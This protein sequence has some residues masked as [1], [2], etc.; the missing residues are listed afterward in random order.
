M[1]QLSLLEYPH[2]PPHR[3]E[4]SQIDGA[5][6]IAPDM[7]RLQLAILQAIDHLDGATIEELVRHTGLKIPT[8]CGRIGELKHLGK[9]REATFKRLSVAGVNVK[10]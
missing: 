3:G 4:P 2:A 6:K 10:V 1:D 5:K 7:N 9:V 8:V